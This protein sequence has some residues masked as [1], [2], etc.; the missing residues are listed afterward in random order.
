M[1][2][3]QGGVGGRDGEA[4]GEGVVGGG[5][6]GEGEEGEGGAVV[7]FDVEGVEA[8]GGCAVGGAR[9]VVF[10]GVGISGGVHGKVDGVGKTDEVRGCRG[11]G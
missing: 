5:E 1:E 2:G 10:W 4:V 3:E 7:G 6:V 11:R 8:E 9:A